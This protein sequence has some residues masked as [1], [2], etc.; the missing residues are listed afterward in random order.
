[1]VNQ[2][3]FLPMVPDSAPI[4]INVAQN[5][6]DAADYAGR[7]IFNL[8]NE[9]APYV[10][11]N[12]TAVF[13]GTK[14]DGNAFAYPANVVSASVVRV[15]LKKQM[16]TTAGRVICS[17]IVSNNEGT[18]GSFNVWL[19]VQ[20][21]ALTGG[22]ASETQL[23]ALVAQAEIAADRAE[24]AADNAEA[25]SAY[26]PYIGANGNWFV[27]DVNTNLYVDSGVFAQGRSGNKWYSGTAVA[28]KS[29]TPASY[30]TGIAYAYENDLYLN[31]DEAAVYHC[32]V[33]GNQSTAKWVYDLTLTGSASTLNALTDVG[34]SGLADGDLLQ[35]D[36]VGAKWENKPLDKSIVRYA[37]SRTFASL[38]TDAAT[39][40]TSAYEDMF[41]LI[42]DGGAIGSG[43][44]AQY[45][46]PSFSDGDII[47]ADS[48]IAVINV[49]K[50]TG[51]PASY[52]FDEFGGFVDISGKADKTE[53]I[54]F[55][56]GSALAGATSVTI[57]SNLFKTTSV[58]TSLSADNGTN[59]AVPYTSMAVSAGQCVITCPALT[60]NTT[61]TVGVY[62]PV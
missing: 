37:G 1:M 2:Q 36:S 31:T 43:E 17:L 44:A 57:N 38:A 39:L 32:S 42:T 3:F 49:N 14:P 5:D 50:G 35:Y 29:T 47:P 15:N 40:L 18:V 9:G 53:I 21:S 26:P 16:T 8:V 54:H 55:A 13:E 11:T 28:G 34:I 41:F 48:H 46:V 60:A 45:W 61:F 7:L 25:W 19:E 52:K 20:E 10:M 27:W 30:A 22:D 58:V 33:A 23:P 59:N 62:N 56:T 6:F 24:Q 12:A 4:V 51:N